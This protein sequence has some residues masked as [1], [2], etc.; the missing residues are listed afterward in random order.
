MATI[1][2]DAWLAG[3]EAQRRQTGRP[4]VTLSWAQSIDGSLTTRRGETLSLS[5]PASMRLTHQLRAAHDAI[6]VGIGTVLADDPQL[7][8]RLVQGQDPQPVVLDSHL[9]FPQGARLFQAAKLPWLATVAPANPDRIASFEAQGVRILQLPADSHQRV[10]LPAFLEALASQGIS[11]IIVEGGARLL[12]SFLKGGLADRVIITIA[13][14]LVGGLAVVN[15][16]LFPIPKL[17]EVEY[18]QLEQ[19]LIV[20]GVPKW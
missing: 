19:D 20:W 18:Q 10:D 16:R 1:P 12:T 6:V 7:T 15:E 4:L 17:L 9:V 14:V 11:S 5:G 3:A 13:P 8:V 2:I